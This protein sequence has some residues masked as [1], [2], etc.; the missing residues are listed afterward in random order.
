MKISKLIVFGFSITILILVAVSTVSIYGTFTSARGFKDYRALA[1][2]TNLAARLQANMLMTRMKVKDFLINN[3]QES[4]DSYHEYVR[5]MHKYL[6]KA[7][8]EILNTERAEK[9]S[10]IAHSVGKYEKSFEHVAD[11]INKRNS[12]MNDLLNHGLQMRKD[13]TDITVSAFKD[14]NH[15]ASFYTARMQE[16]ILLARYYTLSYMKTN[17]E[18]D[19]ETVHSEI[20]QKLDKLIPLAEKSIKDS[21][22]KKLLKNFINERELFVQTVGELEGYIKERNNIVNNTLDKIGPLMT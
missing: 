19:L 1:R 17:S 9:I 18:T 4:R 7:Q 8:T 2:D 3:S 20:G 6:E 16:H 15:E 10:F 5:E 21:N 11:I 22:S 14:G 13:L 12:K